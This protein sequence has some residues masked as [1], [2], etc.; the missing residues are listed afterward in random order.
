[1]ENQTKQLR[2]LSA[3]LSIIALARSFGKDDYEYSA[4][5]RPES[6]DQ[7]LLSLLKA[8]FGGDPLAFFHF[9]DFL[10]ASG[11]PC[12]YDHWP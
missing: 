6:K 4:T 7:F 9:E 5:V 10:K 12:E 1:M 11:I 3:V 8:R 2:K